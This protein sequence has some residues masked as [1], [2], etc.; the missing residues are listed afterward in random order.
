[1]MEELCGL[2]EEQLVVRERERRMDGRQEGDD[3]QVG[4]GAGAGVEGEIE[5][6]L[7][8][9]VITKKY[10]RPGVRVGE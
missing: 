8:S 5:E 4:F 3:V 6:G 1:M 7:L 2:M 9:Q 10:V